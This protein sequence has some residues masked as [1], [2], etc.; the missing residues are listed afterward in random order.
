MTDTLNLSKEIIFSSSDPNISRK[1]SLAEKA[2]KLKKIAPKI[3]TTNLLDSVENIIKRNLIEILAWRYPNAV[4]SHRSAQ[5]LRPTEEGEFFLTYNFR[6]KIADLP[7]INLNIYEGPD[8]V[9][10]DVALNGIYIASEY[11]WML[12][13]MQVSKRKGE[14]SKSLPVSFIENRLEKMIL[15]QGEDKLNEFRDKLREVSLLLNMSVEF[16]KLNKIISAL[17]ATHDVKVLSNDSSKARAAGV[18]FDNSRVELFSVLFDKLK[19]HFF[20]ERPNKNTDENSYRMFSFFESY[21]SN[22]IEGTKFTIDEAKAIVETGIAIPKRIKDSHDILGTFTVI[23]NRAEMSKTPSTHEE[24]FDL[25]QNRHRILMREREECNPGLFKTVNN[26]AGN[27]LFV[28]HTLVK[29]TLMQGFKYYV[30][31]KEPMAKAIFMMFM[32][33]EVHPFT[34]GNGRIARIMMNAELFRGDQS[35]IIVP[36]VFR[37]D[38]ILALRKLTRSKDPDTYI[39]VMEKLHKFSDN[40]YGDDFEDLNN[41]LM[42][43]N[44][45]EDP[46]K[47]HLKYIERVFSQRSK[48][49]FDR[50]LDDEKRNN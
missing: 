13:C 25:L 33:S 17:L 22:Y 20:T 48:D 31:L 36:T 37:E 4:I 29:G 28:D 35:R 16:E 21:F 50:A 42:E 40:L 5:E 46:D 11:R 38:Y 47:A 43:C 49:D 10:G 41:Y 34:D 18:P 44:A 1:I 24:L 3:F 6:K 39:R 9:D 14:Q 2:G 27:T 23:S 45:Y 7:G 12:E 30:A 26:Q 32:I 19:D 8:A 15:I